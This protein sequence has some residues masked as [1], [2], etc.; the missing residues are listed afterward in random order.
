MN[1][2]AVTTLI[3]DLDGVVWR[4]DA[5]IDSAISAIANLRAGGKQCLFCTNNSGQTQ[6]TFVAK[7]AAMGIPGVREEEV[8]TSSSATALYLSAQYTGPFLAYVVGGEGIRVA[9]QKIGARIVPDIDI[10]DD[11]N[12]D[13]VVAGIDQ[14][15]TYEKLRVATRLIRR[16]ALFIATNRDATFPIENGDV[17]PGAGAIISAIETASASAPVTIG[18][19]RPVMVQLAMQQY[20]LKPEQI[21]VIGDRLD[22][23]IVCARR[24]GV[25]AFLVTTGVTTLEQARRAKGELRPDAVFPDLTTFAEMVLDNSPSSALETDDLLTAN[26]PAPPANESV[27]DTAIT[28]AVAAVAAP[29]FEIAETPAEGSTPFAEPASVETASETLPEELPAPDSATP[30]DLSFAFDEPTMEEPEAI[31]ANEETPAMQ[32]APTPEADKPEGWDDSW[33]EENPAAENASEEN[34]SEENVSEENP[35]TENPATETAEAQNS[36]PEPVAAE[37]SPA[38]A[39]VETA[40]SNG[41]NWKLD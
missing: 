15:F 12:V 13:C 34:A 33:F 7:L 1:L 8:I 25:A 41:F 36:E 11:T 4:G 40:E 19:P 10:D 3:F 21:A 39:P 37:N 6:A 14:S 20:G 35:A 30:D 18:K 9:I 27:S 32:D 26:T 23:D 28:P 16:G 2:G 38:S 5:P 31:V 22:T 24:A 29:A 17:V